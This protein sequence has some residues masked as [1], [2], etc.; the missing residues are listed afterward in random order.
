MV[1]TAGELAISD[2][3]PARLGFSLSFTSFPTRYDVFHSRVLLNKKQ[4][5]CSVCCE[6]TLDSE[7][8][9]LDTGEERATVPHIEKKRFII[10]I[11]KLQ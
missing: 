4:S 1:N 3:S 6:T 11:V 9:I 8:E 2:F 7:S 5:V 10:M